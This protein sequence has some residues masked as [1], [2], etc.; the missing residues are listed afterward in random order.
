MHPTSRF[1][2][3]SSLL[4]LLSAADLYLI[5]LAIWYRYNHNAEA[6]HANSR[7]LDLILVS[8]SQLLYLVFVLAWLF[9]WMNFYP[10][11]PIQ[12]GAILCGLSLS[13]AAVCTAPFR[14]NSY[15]FITIIVAVVTAGMWL[16]AALGSVAA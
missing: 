16:L 3:L 7:T 10:G 13:I 6:T 9:R 8:C 4:L 12:N 11:N 15:S 1:S 2:L 5:G 14:P